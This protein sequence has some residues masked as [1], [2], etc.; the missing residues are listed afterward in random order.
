MKRA[1]VKLS[2]PGEPPAA[3]DPVK[4]EESGEAVELAVRGG[5]VIATVPGEG[6]AATALHG[7]L[8][9]E[10]EQVLHFEI[11]PGSARCAFEDESAHL[12][13]QR[14]ERA[15]AGLPPRPGG[16]RTAEE[17][18][19]RE[20]LTANPD[21]LVEDIAKLL[22]F[23]N[24]SGMPVE[25][26]TGKVVGVVSEADVIGKIGTTVDEVMSSDVIS[27]R[28][29][30]PLEEIATLMAQ[31][32]IKRVPVMDNESLVGIISRAD[33]VRALAG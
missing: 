7:T 29:D 33:I 8:R 32:R 4:A 26:A 21:M 3:A 9:L 30:T 10:N 19:T 16:T 17:I 18:M 2:F 1:N 11:R 23:H 6:G 14:Q 5:I 22:T 20:V 31:Q 28:R 25:D 27:V 12:H 15:A 24:I 13:R